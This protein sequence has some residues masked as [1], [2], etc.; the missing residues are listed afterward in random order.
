MP[1]ERFGNRM[2]QLSFE[3]IR[4]APSAEPRFEERVKGVCLIP[5]AGEFVYATAPVLRTLGIGKQAAENVHAER[6]RANLLVS[7]DQLAADL[8]NCETVLLVVAWFGDDLRC[9]ACEIRPGVEVGVKLTT[10][11]TW[12]A[13][14]V[15]R[16]GAH[17]VSQYQGAPAFGGTP[18]DNTVLQAIAELK[19]RGYKVA[20]YPFL[21][22]DVPAGNALPDPYG[23]AKQ[24][25][26]PW[27]GRI[28][29]HPAPG[30][31]GTPDKTAAAA[32]QVAAFFGAAAPAHF[33]ASG[34]VPNYSGPNEWSYRRFILHNAKLAAL[35]GVDAFIIGSELRGLTTA[36]DSATTYPA[37]AALA[38]LA[39]D[40][41]DGWAGREAH[42]RRRLVRIRRPPPAGRL[43]RRVLPPGSALVARG[44]RRDRR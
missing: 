43:R 39:T 30:Q 27:R 11:I 16:G 8:P 7:L 12:R 34:G 10:P 25:A 17:V 26:Y 13:G 3:T 22:M 41:R 20:L 21:L 37:V 33:G 24:A 36:R 9:S 18:S 14:S 23:G 15:D 6:D 31:P 29:V 35:A 5:G 40:V 32:A 4:P 42:L 38:A 28:S 44:D 1:L 2:P 19:A